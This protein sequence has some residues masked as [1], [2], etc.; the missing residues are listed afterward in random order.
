MTFHSLQVVT[1]LVKNCSVVHLV[2]LNEK[3][4]SEM[5]IWKKHDIPID[6]I[7]LLIAG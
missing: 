2:A 3:M 1:P 4:A 6:K 7:I 5:L